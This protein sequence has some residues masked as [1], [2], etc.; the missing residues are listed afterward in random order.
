MP[1]SLDIPVA[2][3]EVID[4]ITIL[5]IKSERI[6]DPAKLANVGRELDLLLSVWS[7]SG[8][9]NG[10]VAGLRQQLKG[11]NEQLWE[12][13]DDIR[14]LE[15]AG[16]FGPD[17]IELARSVYITNDQRAALKRQINLALGSEILEEKSYADYKRRSP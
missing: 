1:A 15:Q 11:V 16:D 5:E 9:E 12:I 2:P 14:R 3:G 17:F 8:L 10:K 6:D 13:E 7:A 4:K